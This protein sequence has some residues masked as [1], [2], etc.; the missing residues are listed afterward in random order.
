[1]HNDTIKEHLSQSFT[2]FKDWDITSDIVSFQVSAS[3]I[4]EVLTSLYNEFDF[5][6]LTDLTAVHYP[7]RTKEE[8]C[9]VYHLHN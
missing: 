3:Q 2:S 4:I 5:Q 9:V 8:L 1:M 7:D 6:F